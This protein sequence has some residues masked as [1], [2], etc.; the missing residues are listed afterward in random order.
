MQSINVG[1]ERKHY[2]HID[3]YMKENGMDL[4]TEL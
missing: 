2:S 3:T 1:L 4:L